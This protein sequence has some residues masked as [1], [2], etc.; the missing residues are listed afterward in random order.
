MPQNLLEA[1]G[2]HFAERA[3]LD[4][5]LTHRSYGLPH[6]E[7]VEFIGDSVLNCVVAGL[8]YHRFPDL[9]EGQLSRLRANLVNRETLHELA[10]GLNLGAFLRLGDGEARSGGARRPSI[11]ADALEA[12][13]GAIYLDGGFAAAQ[14]VIARLYAEPLSRLAVGEKSKDA[15]TRLQE[16]LQGRRLPL[17]AYCVVQVSG[18][19]H[20]QTFEVRCDVADLGVSAQGIGRSRRA[21]EQEAAQAALER[22]GAGR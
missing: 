16:L 21:A 7:R 19:A 11:L 12:V 13:F 2:Y 3:L 22:I 5:A 15:K 4:Q 1:L 20:S 6:N 14:D 8:L 18:E 10:L 9:P 17:P